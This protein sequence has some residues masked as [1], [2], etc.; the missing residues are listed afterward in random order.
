MYDYGEEE[1]VIAQNKK[2]EEF[3]KK[4][5]D[6][7]LKADVQFSVFMNW[8]SMHNLKKRETKVTAQ[9]FIN[10]F[11]DDKRVTDVRQRLKELEIK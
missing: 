11:R 3:L 2:Y 9:R 10:E 5:P 6:S 7:D 4:Y 1:S 8:A